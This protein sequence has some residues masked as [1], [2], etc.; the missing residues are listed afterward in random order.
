MGQ[1]ADREVVDAGL[2]D[3]AR[4]R[5]SVS[6]PLASSL[7]RPADQ[8]DR[9]APSRR[10]AC[11]PAGSPPRR[12]PA[13]RRS[14]RA[15]RPRP[16]PGCPGR[17]ARTARKAAATPP[18]AITWL[19][20]IMRRV[21]QRHAV[22]HA[23][24]AA[25]RVLLQR[26]QPGSGLAGVPD[27]APGAGHRVDPAPGRGGD[28]GQPA[29]QVERGALGRS[30]G[31]GCWPR[32]VMSTS[33][34][35]TR[36]PSLARRSTAIPAPDAPDPPATSCSTASATASPAT[37][38]SARATKSAV[39]D[40]VGRDGRVARDVTPGQVLGERGVDHGAHR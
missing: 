18:A 6:P 27:P 16:R 2:G 4:A 34:R 14:G 30:A 15:G 22:V 10:P 29:E 13:P 37:T 33:P 32:T 21:G 40:M 11:C 23:A 7:A 5:S 38:P 25:H 20:L 28:A 24:A 8:R 9:L 3:L 1:R 31:R 36:S 26:A 35:S 19:S 39:D 12:R 17:A